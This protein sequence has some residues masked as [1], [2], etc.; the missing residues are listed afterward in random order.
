[1]DHPRSYKIIIQ[2][3]ILLI[4]THIDARNQKSKNI[5]LNFTVDLFLLARHRADSIPQCG[6]SKANSN[7]IICPAERDSVSDL[8]VEPLSRKA[9]AGDRNHNKL[10]SAIITKKH[11]KSNIICCFH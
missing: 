1:V 3:L 8:P 4:K 6:I 7:S 11:K 9:K 5:N 2:A 10:F